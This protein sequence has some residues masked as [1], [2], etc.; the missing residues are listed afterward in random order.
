MT[1]HQPAAA[2][3]NS[4]DDLYLLESGRLVYFGR[5]DRGAAYFSSLGM[6]CT[7]GCNPAGTHAVAFIASLFSQFGFPTS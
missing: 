4:L 5:L 1:I 3:F 2:V 7:T 6:H